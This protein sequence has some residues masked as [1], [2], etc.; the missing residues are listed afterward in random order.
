MIIFIL[1]RSHTHKV[2]SLLDDVDRNDYKMV[3][4]VFKAYTFDW[5]F[6]FVDDS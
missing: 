3:F 5:K 1:L 6:F 2:E 4:K